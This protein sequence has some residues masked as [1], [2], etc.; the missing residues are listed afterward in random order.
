MSGIYIHI[1]FCK[2]ACHYCDFHFSTVLK[3]KN[4]FLNALQKE[5]ITRKEYLG[6][7]NINTIYFGGGTP[8]LLSAK[9]INKIIESLNRNFIIEP[10]A[11]ITLE[12][13]PDDLSS[14]KIHELASTPVNR[15]SIG[16]QSFFDEDLR[17]MN[18]AHNSKMAIECVKKSQEEGFD[19]ITIDLIYGIPGLSR[20]RWGKNLEQ[21]F[22]LNVQHISSYCLT[23]EPKTAFHNMVNKKKLKEVED[24]EIEFQFNIMLKKMKENSFIHYEISNF[25][26]EGFHSKHNSSYWTGHHYLGLGPSAHSFNGISRQ[27]NIANNHVYI[28]SI[29]EGKLFYEKENL[30]ETK[31]YNEYILTS[32]RTIWGIE[33]SYLKKNF[34]EKYLS[35][36]TSVATDYISKGQLVFSD[37]KYVLTDAGK[38]YSDAIAR[39]MFA[40]F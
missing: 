19:N 37:Y 23:I 38:L 8:S 2:K 10:G 34:Q 18:R 7:N 40:D 13:N 26:K 11:E 3:Y 33:L 15:L 39:E 16:I 4:D 12:A 6:K 25:C 14:E 17:L 22:A 5:I 31:R 21:A 35:H 24:E 28:N 9:E 30:D 32:I 1:P 20:E 29:N 27:H 36:F